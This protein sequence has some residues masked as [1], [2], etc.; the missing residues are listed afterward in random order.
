[1]D[2]SE[3]LPNLYPPWGWN[4]LQPIV[5]Y[6][7]GQIIPPT[8]TSHTTPQ[9]P[10]KPRKPFRFLDLPGEIR[11]KVYDLVIPRSHVKISGNH[12]QKDLNA[13]RNRLPWLK[14]KP[15]RYRLSGC[16]ISIDDETAD[17]LGLI[18]TCRR[19]YREALP[20]FYSKTVPCFDNLKTINKFL[21]IAPSIGLQSM[22]SIDLTIADYGEPRMT[23]DGEWKR[24]SDG[25][26]AYTCQRLRGSLPHLENVKIDLTLATWPTTL[27]MDASWTRPLLML[28][29]SGLRLSEVTLDHH[30]FNETRLNHAGQRISDRMMTEE[31]RSERDLREAR[32]V[33][34]EMELELERKA[35]EAKKAKRVLVIRDCGPLK[36]ATP[37]AKSASE[38]TNAQ[39]L[40]GPNSKKISQSTK[41]YYRTKGLGQFHRVELD[42][43]GVSWIS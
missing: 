38:K 3:A 20:Y 28:S 9:Q 18:K 11:N 27:S 10:T 22:I 23:R 29:G 41:T 31:G 5:K 4:A 32:R 37:G 15:Q 24:K 12:P 6:P 2:S 16:I 40:E 1:M 8:F 25:R 30:M 43:I 42:M 17:P 36:A 13:I 19:I 35:Q 14:H 21:N 7:V 39:Q 26:W 33:A 34:R